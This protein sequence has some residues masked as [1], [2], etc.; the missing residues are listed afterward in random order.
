ML[1]GVAIAVAWGLNFVA[2]GQGLHDLPPL[3]F[4]G[5][6][7]LFAALPLVFFVRAPDVPRGTVVL[8]GLLGG[9]GQFGLLFLGVAA[10][11]PAG[12]SSVVL[13]A[14]MPF[15][16]LLGI[17]L[18]HERPDRRQLAGLATA[19]LGLAVVALHRGQGVPLAAVLLVLGGGACWAGANVV[20]RSARSARPF[21]LLVHS[22]AVAAP[23]MLTL[24]VLVEGPR[25]DLAALSTIGP[26]A[27]LSLAYVVVVATVAGYGAWYW[28]LSR[29]PSSSVA[30]FPLLAPVAALSSAWLVLGETVPTVQLIG[31]GIAVAGVALAV[32]GSSRTSTP[33]L[34][35]VTPARPAPPVTAGKA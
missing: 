14:Q 30:V 21:S 20:A 29:Y 13:Q 33:S 22:S 25:R 15:T 26:T 7:Y 19:V 12:L 6:R 10:G 5:L 23:C 34:P 32:A 16:V 31:A 18:L 2:I 3:L 9:V 11:M 1:L 27:A 24:S 4:V 17:V 28:L 8:L 35:A